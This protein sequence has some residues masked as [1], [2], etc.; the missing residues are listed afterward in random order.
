MIERIEQGQ[1][2]KYTGLD[3]GLGRINNHIYN[4]QRKW[5]Y[6]IGGLSNTGKTTFVDFML[7]NAIRDAE[8]QGIPIDIF[9]YSYEIDYETKFVQWLSNFIFYKYNIEIPPEK[10]SGLGQYRLTQNEYDL[11]KMEIPHFEKLFKKIQFR[12]DPTN[13]TGIYRELLQYYD[14]HGEFIKEKYAGFNDFGAP[15]QKERISGYRAKDNRY[16]IVVI[17]H[18]ALLNLER[19]FSLKENIDKMSEY[20]VKFRN[21]CGTTFLILQQF[22]QGLHAIDRKKHKGE[23]LLPQQSD[24]KDSGNPFQDSDT[25]LGIMNP[26]ALD[27]IKIVG[28]DTTRI[29]NNFRIV[30][31]IK[32]RKGK[33][34]VAYGYYYNPKAGYFSIIPPP[35]ELTDTIINAVKNGQYNS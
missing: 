7:L 33:A 4:F 24:F 29:K 1:Q 3:N 16:V 25:A 17:D 28:Y 27:L 22:N 10:I 9:Y 14:E 26:H 34:H 18:I 12:F 31:I 11:V 13:P 35:G 32:N 21:I 30:N 15:E 8:E 23:D 5:Y 2:G 19:K 6:L 20:A